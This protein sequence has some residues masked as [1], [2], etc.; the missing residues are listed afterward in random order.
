[1][2]EVTDGSF[3]WSC[4][5]ACHEEA[6]IALM[7]DDQEDSMTPKEVIEYAKKH[8]VRMVDFR[9]LDFPGIW[10]HFSVPISEFDESS[11]EDGYGFDGSSIRGWMPINASDM[12]VIP[13]PNTAILDP[14]SKLPTLILICNIVDPVTKEKYSRDPRYI[15]QKAQEYLKFT[16]IGDTAFFGPEAEFFLLD[17][18]RYDSGA[19]F[20]FYAID[21]V[22]GIWN[23]G[24]D[25]NPNLGYKPRHKE[26]YFPVPPTDSQ[27][28]IR[29]EMVQLMEQVGI[30][31]ECQHHEVATA[32]QA[33][34]DMRFSPLVSMGDQ[35]MWFKYIIKNVARR[36]GKTATFM[37]KP[38]FGDNGSGMHTHLSIWKD[39]DPLFAG[40]RYAG[41]SE[42]ALH[43]VGGV[44]KHASALCALTNPTTN[45]YKRLVPG[46]E[47]PVNLAYS[48]RNRSAAL[49][50]PMYSA[51]PKSKR[52]EVRFPDPSCNGYMAFSAILMAALDGIENR[53][54]PGE[55]LDKDIYSLSPEELQDVPSTPSSLEEAL[56]ALEKDSDF[57]VKGDVFT[58][59]VVE[60]WIDY[61]REN[62]VDPVRLRPHPYE[63]MLYYDI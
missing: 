45:S 30:R 17:D 13:D 41:L 48:S 53:I 12:L 35:L 52:I 39:G 3:R 21:S 63:F 9:F 20:G 8:N 60:A 44:L 58:E 22:E 28:D 34:I 24:R 29:N 2:H 1:V 26:G 5:A 61:K 55:P 16:G 57:L 47:A 33:E 31:V 37:P 46:Y 51:S 23:T 7:S 38:L 27:Q 49:R 50:I 43:A 14:F 25:E 11:F 40:D 10:Q 6:F 56:D 19:N 36:H 15:A 62:E 59:D 4:N 42:T 18:I 54:D 32:G